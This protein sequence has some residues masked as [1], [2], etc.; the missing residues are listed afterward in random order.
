MS[1]EFAIDAVTF[2]VVTKDG[3]TGRMSA[4][5]DVPMLVHRREALNEQF[6]SKEVDL[7]IG[8][9]E[10]SASAAAHIWR[11]NTATDGRNAGGT[12]NDEPEI[13]VREFVIGTT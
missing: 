7:V 11:N 12:K 13:V 5:A 6:V 2:T 1:Q 8:R 4:H 9:N 3:P 10:E